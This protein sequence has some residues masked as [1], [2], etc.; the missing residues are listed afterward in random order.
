MEERL[1]QLLGGD[2]GEIVRRSFTGVRERWWWE[3]SLDGGLR[4]CQELDP[5][6]LA[7]E[8]AART[9]RPPEETLRATLQELGLEEAEPV[10]LTFEVP[11]DATPE[12]A[13]GL[14]RERSS[15]PRG[16]AAGVYGRLL[17]RLG[18]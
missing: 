5:E 9:G 10:V 13:S 14:L 12:E 11:G 17:R 15:G 6:R 4:V 3:R 2:A 8:L 1:D 18:G 7:G 16:L